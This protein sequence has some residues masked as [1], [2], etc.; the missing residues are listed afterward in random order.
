MPLRKFRLGKN[1]WPPAFYK[2]H[3][4]LLP[5]KMGHS[6]IVQKRWVAPLYDMFLWKNSKEPTF[7]NKK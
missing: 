6:P 1:W 5:Y 2:I 3:P 7:Y 4:P